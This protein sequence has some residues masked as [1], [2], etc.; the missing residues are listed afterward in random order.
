MEG[1][2][3]ASHSLYYFPLSQP[4]ERILAA[5]RAQALQAQTLR[6][7]TRPPSRTGHSNNHRY[8][9]CESESEQTVG[10][11]VI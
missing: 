10:V 2:G 4:A 8:S 11:T 6:S 3:G 5:L 9:Q 1:D 7:Q